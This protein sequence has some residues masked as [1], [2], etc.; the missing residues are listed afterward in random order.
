MARG[1]ERGQR[2]AM[3]VRRR[4]FGHAWHG[5]ARTIGSRF[6]ILVASAPM[7]T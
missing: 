7:G 2:G 5:L 1:D 4:Q 3:E 6:V